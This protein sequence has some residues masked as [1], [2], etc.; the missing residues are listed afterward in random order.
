MT[1]R[2]RHYPYIV[3]AMHSNDA[4]V[5]ANANFFCSAE[6]GSFSR[7]CCDRRRKYRFA[8]IWFRVWSCDVGWEGWVLAT[9]TKLKIDL[10]RIRL[11]IEF[12]FEA[13]NSLTDMAMTM[14]LWPDFS[15]TI[16]VAWHLTQVLSVRPPNCLSHWCTVSKWRCHQ[17]LF[18]SP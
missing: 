13:C 8:F 14:I 5:A 4:S 18:K 7:S 17:M 12:T 16:F 2:I 6:R 9:T 15:F 3:V 1:E 10:A 11:D